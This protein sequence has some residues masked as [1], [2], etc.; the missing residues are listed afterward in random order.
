MSVL[1]CTLI[2]DWQSIPFDE[3]T[4]FSP[5]HNPKLLNSTMNMNLNHISMVDQPSDSL[6]RFQIELKSDLNL[7]FEYDEEASIPTFSDITFTCF[8]NGDTSI[9]T[10]NQRECLVLHYEYGSVLQ[11]EKVSCDFI[12]REGIKGYLCDKR[13]F[14]LCLYVNTSGIERPTYNKEVHGKNVYNDVMEK[15]TRAISE[16]QFCNWIPDSI[17]TKQYCYDCR[18]ICR[19]PAHSLD[20]VQ[21]CIGAAV[22]MLSIPVAWVPVAALVSE[23]VNGEMQ[24]RL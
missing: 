20:F 22:L 7:K 17:I 9:C 12:S 5:Y 1:S 23:R 8:I 11:L 15:C 24:V 3:C 4:K 18:P 19:S 13:T 2:A 10:E 21:F 14:S 16:N 6:N